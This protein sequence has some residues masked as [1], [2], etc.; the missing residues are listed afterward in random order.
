MSAIAL[1]YLGKPASMRV[2]P[3]PNGPVTATPSRGDTAHGLLS[4]GVGVTARLHPKK[5]YSLPY[6]FL[7]AASA[8]VLLGFYY[9][10]YGL[11]PFVFVD[12]SAVNVLGLD[13]S[14]CGVRAQASPGWIQSSGTLT[15]DTATTAPPAGAAASGVLKLAGAAAAATLQPGVA[16][17][18]AT[19]TAAPVYLPAEAVTVSLWIKASAS[20]SMS[21]QLCGYNTAGAVT[22]T[23]VAAAVAATT[24]WQRFTVTAAAGNGA[25]AAAAFVLPRI[26][27]GGS[28]PA[29]LYVAG[30]QLEYGDTVTGWLPGLGSP[31][32]LPTATPGREVEQTADFATNHTFAL[33]ET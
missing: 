15:V 4:G 3:S 28:A 30:P 2:L 14:T 17:N 10:L 13:T 31:R 1:P 25:L 12:P 16:A 11:G 19:V 22:V 18:T 27:L 26:V 33:G 29:S 6:Q 5:T 23:S 21:L 8:A 9:R 7:D 20:A 24:S 32:V